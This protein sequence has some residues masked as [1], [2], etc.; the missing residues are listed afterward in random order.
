MKQNNKNEKRKRKLRIAAGKRKERLE[1][2]EKYSTS[3]PQNDEWSDYN[4]KLESN[5]KK[6]KI[7]W[8]IAFLFTFGLFFFSIVYIRSEELGTTLY[9]LI[10]ILCY[11]SVPITFWM[12]T[13]FQIRCHHAIQLGECPISLWVF[14]RS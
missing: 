11:V 8:L 3:S 9:L 14:S 6:A 1:Y 2:R 12:G 13:S 7:W 5:K 4:L 10:Y